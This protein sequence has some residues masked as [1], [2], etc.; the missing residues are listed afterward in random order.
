[1]RSDSD[2]VSEMIRHRILIHEEKKH[3]DYD[4]YNLIFDYRMNDLDLIILRENRFVYPDST[5]CLLPVTL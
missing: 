4:V 3:R 5:T 2:S 1:M